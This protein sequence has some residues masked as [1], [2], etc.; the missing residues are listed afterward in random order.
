MF[1]RRLKILSF[2][3]CVNK[4]ALSLLLGLFLFLRVRCTLKKLLK[5]VAISSC[6]FTSLSKVFAMCMSFSFASLSFNGTQIPILLHFSHFVFLQC[7]YCGLER[8]DLT[9]LQDCYSHIQSQGS[10]F[11]CDP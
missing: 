4:F 1:S 7:P 11:A 2:H 8:D 10:F 6:K 5:F 3:Q 9:V